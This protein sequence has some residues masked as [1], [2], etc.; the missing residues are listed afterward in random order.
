VL[1]DEMVNRLAHAAILIKRVFGGRNQD[2]E[3]V[4]RG[5]KLFIVQSRPYIQ[6]D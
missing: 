5:G 2:I 3:W 4:Y 1:T 6:G